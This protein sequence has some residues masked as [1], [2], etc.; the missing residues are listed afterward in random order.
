MTLHLKDRRARR[1]HDFFISFQQHGVFTADAELRRCDGPAVFLILAASSRQ[2]ASQRKHP[3]AP[4]L[5]RQRQ[6]PSRSGSRMGG[7][8]GHQHF[9]S[10]TPLH[11]ALISTR[12][13]HPKHGGSS[14]ASVISDLHM[15]MYSTHPGDLWP[16]AEELGRGAEV[17]EINAAGAQLLCDFQA[18]KEASEMERPRTGATASSSDGGS[19]VAPATSSSRTP[20]SGSLTPPRSL[21][22]PPSSTASASVSSG[23]RARNR[24]VAAA[25]AT[26][27][28]AAAAAAAASG[29][30][31]SSSGSSERRDRLQRER[32]EEDGPP[33]HGA[34]GDNAQGSPTDADQD[35]APPFAGQCERAVGRLRTRDADPNH[36]VER[37]L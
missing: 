14:V 33:Q 8:R 15:H 4:L 31:G 16:V 20:L 21:Y 19:F 10:P 9:S 2:P 23:G 6:T 5:Q 28:G 17:E 34:D 18:L 11:K 25:T 13:R 24:I 37:P 32:Q 22:P 26:A 27:A 30:R 36:P 1:D 3:A 35:V 7:H 12:E 29:T